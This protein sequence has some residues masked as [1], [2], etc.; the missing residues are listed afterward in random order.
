MHLFSDN[1][2]AVSI[3]QVGQ[4]RDAFLQHSARDIRLTCDKWDI[5]L[6]IGHI[7]GKQLKDT[8]DA[9]S[10]WHLSSMYKERVTKLV[11]GRDIIMYQ[12]PDGV[13]NL[14]NEV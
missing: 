2:S 10:R 1:A 3:F 6:A 11:S 7:P 9:L 5:F 8:A 4:G 13:F 12:V 14:S